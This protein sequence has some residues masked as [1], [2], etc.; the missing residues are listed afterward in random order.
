MADYA[1]VLQQ[2]Y[3]APLANFVAERTRL[4]A[5]LRAHGDKAGATHIAKRPKPVTSVWVVNQLYWHAR[6]TFDAMLAAA[7]RVRE[8]DRHAAKAYHDAI[9]TLRQR[10]AVMLRDAGY[11]VNEAT[12]RR[13]ATT[14]AAI[15]AAGGFAPDPPGALATDRDPPGFET[16]GVS[17]TRVKALQHTAATRA[18]EEKERKQHEA[19]R[20]RR[21]AERSRVQSALRAA[22]TEVRTR[23]RALAVLAQEIRTAEKALGDAREIMKDLERQ[24]AELD[25]AE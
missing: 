7:S 23:E 24:L 5:E 17:A 19:E 13:A 21:K 22:T 11:A 6:D 20:A 10:A 16:V 18:A 1:D 12:L 3:Q 9:A 2:L 25:E 4:A 8:G 15:A 14:L